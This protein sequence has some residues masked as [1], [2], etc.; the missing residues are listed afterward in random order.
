MAVSPDG[1][2]W[3]PQPGPLAPLASSPQL[4]RVGDQLR[5]Y[6]VHHGRSIAWIPFEGGASTP[7]AV[8]GLEGGMQV[9]PCIVPLADGGLRLYLV[10]HP[11]AAD[12]GLTGRNRVLSAR[13][14]GDGAWTLEPGV[15]IE[16]AWVDPDVVALPDGGVRMFLTRSTR[17]V[18]SAHSQDGLEFGLEDGLRF[19]GG[20]VTS[21]LQADDGW[22]MYHHE[23]GTLGRARSADGFR[24]G[25]AEHLV[26]PQP[27]GGPWMLESPS[28][29]RDGDRWLMTYVLAPTH[30][31]QVQ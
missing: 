30:A 23:A 31:G 6:Y 15:R 19:E 13:S 22:W 16:G 3:E 28:V 10:H 14:S 29:L 12:P 4:V 25:A 17:E 7:V 11:A 18:A 2:H 24:F 1:L 21:T 8:Q 20:G 26:I 9:D 27:E 5:V